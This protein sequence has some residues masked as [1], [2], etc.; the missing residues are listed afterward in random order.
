MLRK[1]KRQSEKDC[2]GLGEKA[3]GVPLAP[4]LVEEEI[5]KVVPSPIKTPQIDLNIQPDREEEPSPVSDAGNLMRLL[6]DAA[7]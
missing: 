7:A 4:P 2:N 1:E 3:V 6:Q 5:R